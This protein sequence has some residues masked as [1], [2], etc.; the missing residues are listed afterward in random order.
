MRIGE[1]KNWIMGFGCVRGWKGR[2]ILDEEEH[3][4]SNTLGLQ[5]GRCDWRSRI[6][7]KH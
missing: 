6:R 4:E 2:S 3:M 1:L 5:R 7:S